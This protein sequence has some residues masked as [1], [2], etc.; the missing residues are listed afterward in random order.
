MSGFA[1]TA[2]VNEDWLISPKFNLTG[3][4]IPL[5]RFYSRTAFTGSGLVLKVSTNYAGSGNP[6]T[7]TWT[8]LNGRF[9]EGASDVWTLSDSINLSAYN[10]STNVFIAWVYY[11]NTTAAARWT[12]DD[13]AVYSSASL[14]A[15]NI[16]I[17]PSFLIL[18]L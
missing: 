4:P 12:L 5:L 10:T 16:T 14:P 8:D 9:P 17:Q 11:S 15:P 18:E 13:V 7:A 6:S 3:I 2:Q 1:G